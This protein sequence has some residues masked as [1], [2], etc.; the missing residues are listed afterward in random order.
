MNIKG[1]KKKN[2][3]VTANIF[4][5]Q[6]LLKKAE[7]IKENLT[8]ST[9]RELETNGKFDKNKKLSF[10]SDDMLILGCD[11]GSE[12]HYVRAID[13]R[14]RELSKSAYSF[15]NDYEG[16][17]SAKEWAVK[18]A[19]E[20]DKSQIVLGLEPTGHY[21][22]CLATWMIA[23]GISVVQ[24]N[25]YAVKQT[26]EVEDNSQLKDDRKEVNIMKKLAILLV[27]GSLIVSGAASGL[28][29]ARAAEEKKP[30]SNKMVDKD[31]NFMETDE[32]FFAYPSDMP[33]KADQ[34]KALENFLKN[35]GKLTQAEKQSLT[36]NYKKLLTTL[37][38]IDKTYEQIDKVTNKL[39]NNWEIEDKFDVLSNKNVK[40]W[41][42]IYDNATDEDLEIEDNIEFIKSSKALTDKEKETL[43]KTQKEIDA[44]VVEYDKLYNKVEKATKELN[45]KLDSLYEDSE[46]L[47]NKMQP[48]ADKLGK[49]FKENFGC[50]DLYR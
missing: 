44:L 21:W 3:V 2:Q 13:T 23:N 37:E 39:T 40:L 29:T 42:K 26:K 7:V 31:M 41:N 27:A 4:E 17:Q 35:D 5:Q 47:M 28:S 25:P 24:V 33:S 49:K 36:E 12:T 32:D 50:C 20:H 10:I 34:M 6:E 19:A 43:I 46:K 1:T 14:G 11:V 18:I 38:N 48:L 30:S 8:A 9:W 16:F 22:F 15:N 45:A